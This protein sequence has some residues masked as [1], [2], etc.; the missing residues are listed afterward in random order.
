[1]GIILDRISQIAER[2]RITIGALERSIGASKG[3]LSRAILKKTDIQSKWIEKLVENYPDVSPEWLLTGQGEMFKNQYK[4]TSIEK[5]IVNESSPI[6]LYGRPTDRRYELQTIPLYE[7]EISAGLTSL[8]SDQTNQVP[9]G[10]IIIPNAP[11]CDGAIPVRGDSMYPILKAGDIVCYKS[12][13]IENALWGEIHGIYINAD[14][15]EM[16]ATKY[17][18]KS[19]KGDRYVTLVSYNQHHQPQD[20]LIENIKSIAIIKISIRYN[21]NI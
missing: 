16:F 8:F 4:I 9:I 18:Q 20:V 17:L 7:T 19:E 5:P 2:K 11:K 13:N 15:D 10:N 6:T 12:I 14:G 3:V 21:T 1:M